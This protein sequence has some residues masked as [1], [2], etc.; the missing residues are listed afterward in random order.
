MIHDPQAL[1]SSRKFD[2]ILKRLIAFQIEEPPQASR[3]RQPALPPRRRP[4]IGIVTALPVE[5]AAMCALLDNTEEKSGTGNRTGCGTCWETF[6]AR[7]DD[8]IV[9]FWP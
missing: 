9:W 8:R 4:R 7:T 3:P 1:R 5:Y 2:R 6:P